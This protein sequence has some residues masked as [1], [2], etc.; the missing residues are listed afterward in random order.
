MKIKK[1]GKFLAIATLLTTTAAVTVV[2]VQA[3]EQDG[4][5]YSSNGVVKFVP[6]TNGTDPVDPEDPTDPAEPTDP[7][8]PESKSVAVHRLP[9]PENDES[10]PRPRCL[11]ISRP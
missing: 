1:F 5:E 11:A 4:G 9:G 7:T 6:N 8:N 10:T 3:A 2:N